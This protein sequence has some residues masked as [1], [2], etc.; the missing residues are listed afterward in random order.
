MA[1]FLNRSEPGMPLINAWHVA[2]NG[3]FYVEGQRETRRHKVKQAIVRTVTTAI[4]LLLILCMCGNASGTAII[5]LRSGGQ[6]VLASD[7]LVVHSKHSPTS[8]CK[9]HQNGDFFWAASGDVGNSDT[10]YEVQNFLKTERKGNHRDVL[11]VLDQLDAKLTPALQKEVAEIRKGS[12]Q[13]FEKMVRGGGI[14]TIF[15]VQLK[16]DKPEVFQKIFRLT[17][18]RVRPRPATECNRATC[19]YAYP[20][21]I[22]DYLNSH[23]E[24]TSGKDIVLPDFVDRLM[25]VA[26]ASDPS[27]IGPPISI[28]VVGSTG[29]QWVRQG[30]CPNVVAPSAH[31]AKRSPK[32]KP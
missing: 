2:T 13:I 22:V 21:V 3:G 6:V 10:G 8:E 23:P 15:A 9:I 5:S 11:R 19:L 12:P 32:A 14:L 29:A 28:L 17:N 31:P 24:F 4:G 25:Q 18:D 1:R 7:S 20:G 26:Q 16:G 30:F 27:F